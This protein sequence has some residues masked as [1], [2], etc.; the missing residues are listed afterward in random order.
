[1]NILVMTFCDGVAAVKCNNC[2]HL[3]R[4]SV[5]RYSGSALSLMFID[6]I[7]C[8]YFGLLVC[9]QFSLTLSFWRLD[10]L[11][12]IL[13]HDHHSWGKL[14]ASA[15]CS[16]HRIPLIEQSQPSIHNQSPC[17][18]V[19]NRKYHIKMWPLVAHSVCY[20]SELYSCNSSRSPR[21]SDQYKRRESTGDWNCVELHTELHCGSSAV[22]EEL[23]S[24]NRLGTELYSVGWSVAEF[25][26][27]GETAKQEK[28]SWK[29]K[30]LKRFLVWETPGL[31]ISYSRL[32]LNQD[33]HISRK[34][35]PQKLYRLQLEAHSY[36]NKIYEQGWKGRNNIGN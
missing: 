4:S 20:P 5:A 22:G 13:G 11:L 6:I 30:L 34:K 17:R 8:H 21:R 9:Q 31:D 29:L 15:G 35:P 32:S 33:M 19:A 10:K 1:M 3:V 16:K 18:T 12:T 7:L 2:T 25:T 27:P 26:L 14:S 23:L 24:S 36:T 28:Y